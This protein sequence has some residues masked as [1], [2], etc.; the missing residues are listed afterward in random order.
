MI[1]L[2][3]L[4]VFAAVVSYVGGYGD[5]GSTASCIF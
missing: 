3:L 4:V 1:A 2:V 5:A